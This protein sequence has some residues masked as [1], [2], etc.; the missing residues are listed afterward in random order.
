MKFR[1]L[2]NV[3]QLVLVTVEVKTEDMNTP[4][5]PTLRLSAP[6]MVSDMVLSASGQ[7]W[8]EPAT[9]TPSVGA[10]TGDTRCFGF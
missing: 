1:H 6:F 8:N 10:V 3:R 5:G 4:V 9:Q 2:I 7:S